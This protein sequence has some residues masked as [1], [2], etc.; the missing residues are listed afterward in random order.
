MVLS[1]VSDGASLIPR[2]PRRKAA[3]SQ[4]AAS[5]KCRSSA[6]RLGKQVRRGVALFY[7]LA[8]SLWGAAFWL[9]RGDPLALLAL[10]PAALHLGWQVA[11]LDPENGD[12][13]LAR[14][15]SNRLLGA[16]VAAACF[17]VGNA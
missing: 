4:P 14:F 7:A 3:P 6:L 9:M 12:N 5:A 8:V 13:A 15:R 16:L 11:T 10:V 17:V 1:C 2:P